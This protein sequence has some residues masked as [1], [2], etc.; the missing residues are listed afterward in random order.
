MIAKLVVEYGSLFKNKLE[1]IFKDISVSK[2]LNEE[3]LSQSNSAPLGMDLY[4]RVFTTGLWPIQSSSPD[5]SLPAEAE[6]AFNVFAGFYL[7]KH[8][9]HKL[10]LHSNLSHAELSAVF[11][12]PVA[13]VEETTSSSQADPD[14]ASNDVADT[15]LALMLFLLSELACSAIPLAK[16]RIK[17]L[18]V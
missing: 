4:V 6:Q 10:S 1:G 18:A 2:S 14:Y 16:Y 7:G 13:S 8:T 9:S 12:E 3:F 5:V 11:N 17:E 15:L